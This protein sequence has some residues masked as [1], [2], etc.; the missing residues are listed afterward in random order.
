MLLIGAFFAGKRCE[1]LNKYTINKELSGTTLEEY[2]KNKL[3][4]SARNRQKLFHSS[5]VLINGKKAFSKRILKENDIV[6]VKVQRDKDYGVIP[7]KGEV[8]ILYEDDYVIA[9]NKPAGILV[10]PAGQTTRGTLANYL[11]GYF[12]EKKQIIT[13][14]PL[15]RLDRDTSGIVLFAKSAEMQK[16][17]T[18]AFAENK[19][20]RQYIALVAGEL[21]EKEG[22]IEAPIGKDKRNPNRRKI[23]V[24]GQKAI[25]NYKL[26]KTVE[27]NGEK[28]SLV[29]LKL[30]TGRTHQIRVH[31]AHLGNPVLGDRMYGRMS[32]LIKRQALHALEMEFVNPITDKIVK[33]TSYIPN[34]FNDI[35]KF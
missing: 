18:E 26:L 13:I 22:K 6:S 34:D 25:T 10:H 15:H 7:E 3:E 9:L 21:K 31:M 4:I 23:S 17:L 11:A 28:I 35:C 8:E 33:I 12:Q 19:I 16:K 20:H 30:E 1:N 27:V 5:G 32:R 29:E 2:L 24:D 14:R